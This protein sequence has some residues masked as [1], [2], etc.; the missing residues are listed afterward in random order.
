MAETRVSRPPL[1]WWRWVGTILIM[2]TG[3]LTAYYTTVYGIRLTVNEKADRSAVERI[4]H[5]LVEI[6]TILRTSVV[7][8]SDLAALRETVETRLTR[9]ETLLEERREIP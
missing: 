7:H 1:A 5:R 8:R 2:V 9:I 6:E 3:A 4:D